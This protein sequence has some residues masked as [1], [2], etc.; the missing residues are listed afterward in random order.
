MRAIGFAIGV[1]VGW[2]AAGWPGGG[3]QAEISDRTR[4]ALETLNRLKGPDAE[5][6]PSLQQAAERIA[7]QLRGEPEFVEVVGDFRLKG[8]EADLLDFAK[9]HPDASE[10]GDAIRLALDGDGASALR[11]LLAVESPE[12][13]ALLHAISA[14]GDAR[15]V[16]LMLPLLGVTNRP[17]GTRVLVL[18]AISGSAEGASNLLSLTLSEFS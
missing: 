2:M 6:T 18:H 5:A 7:D 16:P 10:A 4:L 13:Q 9:R 3:V 15:A 12:S 14:S 17:M 1:W 8:R 11:P